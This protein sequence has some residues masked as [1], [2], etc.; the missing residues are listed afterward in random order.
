MP[1]GNRSFFQH[2]GGSLYHAGP[3][4]QKGTGILSIFTRFLPFLKSAGKS[5]LKMAGSAAKSAAK[6]ETVKEL[7]RELKSTAISSA[8]DAGLDVLKGEDPR[9]KLKSNVQHAKNLISNT[10]EDKLK[11]LKKNTKEG[12]P[13]PSPP[14]RKSTKRKKVAYNVGAPKTKA[15]RAKLPDEKYDLLAN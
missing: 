7:G 14:K 2:G 5:A 3:A 15:K 10:I 6:S 9:E 13:S 1:L 12:L 11:D 8:V 4:Y